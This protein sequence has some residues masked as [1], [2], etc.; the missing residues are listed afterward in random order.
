MPARMTVA[1]SAARPV[2]KLS[3]NVLTAGSERLPHI[4]GRIATTATIARGTPILKG[5]LTKFADTTTEEQSNTRVIPTLIQTLT[6]H[7]G[8]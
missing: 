8:G 4:S 3:T 1:A 2:K 7:S 5:T 6:P